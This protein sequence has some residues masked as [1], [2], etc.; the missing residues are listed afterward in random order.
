M[1]GGTHGGSGRLA[2]AA[3]AAAWLASARLTASQA[4]FQSAIWAAL[5]TA[6][7]KRMTSRKKSAAETRVVATAAATRALERSPRAEQ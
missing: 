6:S 7:G 5:T 2:A 3:F 1:V 4:H